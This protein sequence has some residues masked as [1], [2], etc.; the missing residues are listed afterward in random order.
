MKVQHTS[1]VPSGCQQSSALIQ[2][3]THGYLVFGAAFDSF[4]SFR[5]W[6]HADI[7]FLSC[8]LELDQRQPELVWLCSRYGHA[9]IRSRHRGARGTVDEPRPFLLALLPACVDM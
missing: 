2:S 9:G 8:A 7:V 5:F 6:T 1:S 3:R 4:R